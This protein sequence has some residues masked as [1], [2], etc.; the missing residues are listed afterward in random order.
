M[1]KFYA[2]YLNTFIITFQNYLFP[3]PLLGQNFSS[4]EYSMHLSSQ[5]M[6]SPHLRCLSLSLCEL[7]WNRKLGSHNSYTSKVFHTLLEFGASSLDVTALWK[8]SY[9]IFPFN[10]HKSFSDRDNKWFRIRKCIIFVTLMAPCLTR[11]TC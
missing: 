4:C 3:A 6:C 9:I 7:P 8:T 11:G 1:S 5:P 10:Y 2:S